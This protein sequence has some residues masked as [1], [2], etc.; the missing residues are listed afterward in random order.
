MAEAAKRFKELGLTKGE[1]VMM[2]N[3]GVTTELLLG[4][5][6]EEADVRFPPGSAGREEVLRVLKDGHG[7]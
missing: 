1:A 4:V 7:K 6:V 2:V 5:V 3:H